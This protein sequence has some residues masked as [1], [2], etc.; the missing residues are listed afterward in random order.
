V[1]IE[2]PESPKSY[3]NAIVGWQFPRESIRKCL[4]SQNPKL[5]TMD[6]D[7]PST[8]P[9]NLRCKYCFI[10][11]D[12]RQQ[13]NLEHKS[14]GRL[15]IEVLKDVFARSSELGCRSAKLIGDQ[16]PLLEADFMSFVEY[17]SEELKMWLVVFTN[18]IVLTNDKLCYRLHGMSTQTIIERLFEMRV[19]VMLKFHS[20]SNEVEDDLV[21]VKGYSSK[22]NIV[23]NNLIDVGFSLS[24]EFHNPKEQFEM[25]GVEGNEI[26]ETWTR[27]G[28]E[29]VVTPQCLTDAERIY[30]LKS[31]KHLF[32]DL[33]PPVPIGLTRSE[34]T[35]KKCGVQ[36]QKEQLLDLACHIYA[37]NEKLGI[38]FEGVSPYLGSLPCSQ[39]PYSL[40]INAMGR[41][42][43]CCGCPDVEADGR[44]DYLGHISETHALAKAIEN[45]PYRKHYKYHGHAYDTPPF[46]QKGYNGY[47]F[48]HGCPYRDRAGDLLPQ[49]WEVA[50]TDY[51]QS[52]REG[53][54]TLDKI[55]ED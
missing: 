52:M 47:G 51:I 41:I 43:P 37:L 44:S 2:M 12:E 8:I 18:G 48:Y 36:V 9:C 54:T 35:R 27:L 21:G 38:P 4:E 16:E 15:N 49:N 6:F 20:F 3:A 7:L 50:V 40:Y 25:T 32:V 34:E 24:P 17:V 14:G 26:P 33:D 53:V 39:L 11:T 42:Y 22:R 31:E 28:L 30:R 45:N 5:L 29:S 13:N 55:K 10:E 19:S 1:V 46:N 23:L